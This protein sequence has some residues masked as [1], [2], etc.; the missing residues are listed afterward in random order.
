MRQMQEAKDTHESIDKN[1]K[2]SNFGFIFQ[3]GL[4]I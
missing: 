1:K 3:K 2:L 4:F